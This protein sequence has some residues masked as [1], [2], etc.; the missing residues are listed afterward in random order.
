MKRDHWH[1]RIG[2]ILAA[3]GSAIGLGNLWKFPYITWHNGGGAFVLVYLA[4]VALVGLPIMMAEILIGR[5]TGQSPVPAFLKLGGRGWSLVGG[6]G[7]LTG[8]VILGYYSV[9]AGWTISSFMQC[10][11]WSFSGY[12]APADSAFGEFLANG[13]LQLALTAIFSAATVSIVWFG[14]GKGIERCTRI[15][16]PILLAIMAYLLITVLLMPGRDQALTFLF[17]PSFAQLPMS[18][19]LESLGHAFFTLSLGMGVMITYGSYL[20]GHESVTRISL[21]VVFMDTLIALMA[22]VI[23]YTIIFSVPGMEDQVAGSTIGMLFLTLPNVFYTQMGAGALIG[24][25]FYILVA[26]AALT[27]TISVLEVI[28]S[29]F[30]DHLGW[31]RR[32]AAIF[33]GFITYCLSVLCAISLGAVDFI[34]TFEVFSGKEGLLSTLD[35]I[36]ANWMLPVGGLLTTIF[37]GWFLSKKI[38]LEQ[39]RLLNKAGQPTAW[40]HIW[41]FLVRFVAPAAILAVIIAVI[42]GKDF[43]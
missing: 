36:A 3:T 17:R 35:H 41:R 12:V 16:M 38:T 31:K 29:F 40:Y 4:S 11:D 5:K 24:P 25:L 22:C 34:S 42:L 37:V 9:I 33:A 26:F 2:F 8:F 1:S 19:I 10:L 32:N 20:Q 7:V 23:M 28:V 6:L 30:I 21:I 15:L 13:P 14:V 27:S 43:S 39:L 18:G